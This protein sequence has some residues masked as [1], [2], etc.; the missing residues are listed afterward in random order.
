MV[1]VSTP[2]KPSSTR[3]SLRSSSAKS[4]SATPARKARAS[5]KA[6]AARPSSGSR[7]AEET[8]G[9]ETKIAEPATQKATAEPG[10]VEEPDKAP[11]NRTCTLVTTVDKYNVLLLC[12]VGGLCQYGTNL[13]PVVIWGPTDLFRGPLWPQVAPVGSGGGLGPCSAMGGRLYPQYGRWRFKRPTEFAAGWGPNGPKA[14]SDPTL[15]G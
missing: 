8:S 9:A 2:T 13:T 11:D 14:H 5:R 12:P 4:G 10:R 6:Q 7:S 3:R 15:W 1:T